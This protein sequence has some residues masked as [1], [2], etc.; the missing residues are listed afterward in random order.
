MVGF[1]GRFRVRVAGLQLMG[2]ASVRAKSALHGVAVATVLAVAV[3][4][5]ANAQSALGGL[6]GTD[7]LTLSVGGI[8]VVT[9]RYEGG[10]KY[11][12]IGIPFIAPGGPETDQDR[13]HIKGA[14][15]LRVRLFDVQ[16]L[17]IGALTGWRFG[18]KPDDEERLRGTD[19]ITGGL[20]AG[21]YVTYH[22][23]AISP[24]VSYHHQ[25]TGDDTGGVLRFGVEAKQW[26]TPWLKLTGVVGSS[27]A[28][29]HYMDKFF[30][31]TAAQSAASHLATFDAGAGIKDVYFELGSAL[32]LDDKWTLKVSGRYTRLVGDAAA[33]SVIETADQFQGVV[34]L[35][36]D[37][38]VPLP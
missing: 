27:Y 18:R 2:V 14:D 35:S 34:S 8:A 19:K 15:D 4:S 37:F 17:E 7:Q 12:A 13:F 23:G 1:V 25:V 22:M 20:I 30:S 10:N 33:S 3:P 16:N 31:I 6:F 5:A 26:V 28:D 36:Y 29:S 21:A 11:R 32:K 24:F 38:T 9:P